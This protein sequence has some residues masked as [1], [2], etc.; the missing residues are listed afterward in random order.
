MAERRRCEWLSRDFCLAVT[1][2]RVVTLAIGAVAE[3]GDGDDVMKSGVK[4]GTLD[5]AGAERFPVNWE[6]PSIG[7]L[8]ELLARG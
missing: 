6:G 1:A 8:V 2:D 7:G 4:G 3:A 5:L